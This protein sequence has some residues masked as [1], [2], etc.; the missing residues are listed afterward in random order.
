MTTAASDIPSDSWV[1]RWAP[2]PSQPYLR[3][4][5]L[6]RPIGTW[7]L[8]FPCWWSLALVQAGAGLDWRGAL[9]FGLLFGVGAV[10]MRGAGC[11]IND[12]WDRRIDRQVAR[13]RT[14]PIASG[15]V[16]IPAAF[17]FLAAQMALG[18]A[19]LVQFN[20]P[21]ILWGAASLL[22]VV[23]YPLAKRVTYWPQAVLGL[24]FNWGALV[25]W[26]AVAGEIAAPALILYVA[27][28]FW[29]LGYDTIYAHQ[30][31]RDDVQVGVKST[32]LRLGDASRVW[33][34]GFFAVSWGLLAVAGLA[35]GLRAEVLLPA[36]LPAA[37]HAV[38]QVRGWRLDDPADCLRRFKANRD[39]G[40]LV[41]AGLIVALLWSQ[42]ANPLG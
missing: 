16:S 14:R 36:L 39:Y 6:D 1:D 25:G 42:V 33:V 19:I 11:T 17:A 30:D 10:V 27:G 40:A 22:L 20:L 38:W 7:L 32:A 34:A 28:F 26:T 5:R 18:L 24:T 9:W 13:T 21:T 31:K 3:L 12:L 23:T 2:R 8:L 4:M 29:T 37:A 15:Q 41:L 35:A